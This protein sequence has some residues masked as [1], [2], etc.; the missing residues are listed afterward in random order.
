MQKRPNNSRCPQTIDFRQETVV[1]TIA[2]GLT[3][4]FG[5]KHSPGA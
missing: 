2:A 3:K 4:L 5:I 1:T